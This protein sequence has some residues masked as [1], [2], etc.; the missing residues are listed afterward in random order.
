[1][2]DQATAVGQL[3]S[4]SG[5]RSAA[6]GQGTTASGADATAIGNGAF[7]V[8]HRCDGSGLCDWRNFRELHC[9]RQFY[10]YHAR[11]PGGTRHDD[12]YLHLAGIASAAS[13][14]AQSGPVEV[15]TTDVSGNLASAT[16]SQLGLATAG[17]IAGLQADLDRTTEGVAM[18]MALSGIPSVLPDNTNLAVSANWGG[19]D[20]EN[21]LAVGGAARLTDNVFVSGGGAVGT[22]GRGNGGG[23]AGVT[24]AW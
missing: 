5:F 7:Y 13:T 14:A 22:G 8:G 9:H 15:V 3:S 24:F 18:A 23:R 21:A 20:H 6:F 12:Q 11:Q 4:A 1:M 2:G 19:F 17:D 16:F 10:K